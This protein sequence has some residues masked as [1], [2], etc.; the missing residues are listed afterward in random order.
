VRFIKENGSLSIG[1]LFVCLSINGELTSKLFTT[2]VA[3]TV[4]EPNALN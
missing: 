4:Y 3:V 1:E 2:A